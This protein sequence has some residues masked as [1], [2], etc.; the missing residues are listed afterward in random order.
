GRW[1]A[2]TIDILSW[3]RDQTLMSAVPVVSR[4]ENVQVTTFRDSARGALGYT[5]TVAAMPAAFQPEEST[6]VP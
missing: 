2:G 4:V 6:H 1:P 5:L 3:S